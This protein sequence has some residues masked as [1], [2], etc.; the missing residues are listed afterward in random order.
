MLLSLVAVVD[1][2]MGLGKNNA[3]LCH[4]P[5]DLLHFKTLTWGKPI[6]MGRK[7]Y[8]SIGKPLPGRKNIVISHHEINQSG[9]I[10]APSL[11]A[12]I[13]KV[14]D[15]SEVMIIGG[16]SIYKQVIDVADRIYLTVIHH[17]FDADVYFPPIDSAQWHCIKSDKRIRD[18]HN[19]FDMTFCSYE[20]T[21]AILKKRDL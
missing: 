7:T 19:A 14:S 20:R 12:A 11:D 17:Q 2:Q 5:A 13:A 21:G 8:E 4:L 1:E 18:S 3:L 16:A 6:I 15:Q 9:I 10:W